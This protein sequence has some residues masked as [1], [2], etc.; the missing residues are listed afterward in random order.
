MLSGSVKHE[1]KEALARESGSKLDQV[2]EEEKENAAEATQEAI[3]LPENDLAS[4]QNPSL[5]RSPRKSLAKAEDELRKSLVRS[6][7][8]K[9]SSIQ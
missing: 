7:K 8:S 4:K 6:V 2:L 9:A 1:E 5:P 3:N